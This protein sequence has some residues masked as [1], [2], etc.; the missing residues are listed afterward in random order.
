MPIY[1]IIKSKRKTLAIHIKKDG[2]VEIRAPLSMPVSEIE[3]FVSKKQEW[4]N[5]TRERML[6]KNPVT[7]EHEAALSQRAAE[8]IP[9]RTIFFAG[10]MGVCP[11][12]VKIGSAKTRFGSCNRKG[13][14]NFS[15]FLML[16]EEA[17]V[18]YVIVHELA[19]LRQFNHGK[20][21]WRIV[22]SV[23]PDYKSRREKLKKLNFA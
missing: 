10:I 8:Y 2:A 23:L 14:L 12:A 22:E 18:D 7:K 15:H 5:K 16:A 20:E 21:F 1:N 9:E 13:V 6:A 3:K 17:E 19:H 4:I 11:S